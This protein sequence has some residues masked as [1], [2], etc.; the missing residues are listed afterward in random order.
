MTISQTVNASP[1][2]TQ[3]LGNKGKTMDNIIQSYVSFLKKY[4]EEMET[5]YFISQPLNIKKATKNEI[6]KTEEKLS[7]TI[8]DELK[9]YYLNASNGTEKDSE[10]YATSDSRLDIFSHQKIF[11]IYDYFKMYWDLMEVDM[12][13]INEQLTKDDIRFVNQKNSEYFVFAVDWSEN[14]IETFVFDKNHNFYRFYFDQDVHI[15]SY[16]NEMISGSKSMK[17]SKSGIELLS[18]YL[19]EKKEDIIKDIL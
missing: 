5:K 7:I 16:I 14:F 12:D 18:D 13:I 6:E 2:E 10:K 9:N 15:I 19:E 3:K 11:G 8:P 1:K 17:K 4:D